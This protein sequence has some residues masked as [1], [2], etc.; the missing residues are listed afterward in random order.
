MLGLV[1]QV[2]PPI[3]HLRDLRVG[4]VRMGP[5]VVRALLLPLP[6]EPRQIR[7]RRRLDA[8]GL[9]QLRQEVLI[10][11][12]RVAPHDAAQRRVGL[13]RRRVDADRLALDQA[14]VRQP[15]QHPREDGLVRLEIDQATRA[16]DRRMVRRRLRQHQ[17]EKL[18]QRK[19][20]GRTP[21][22]RALRVQAFEIADQQQPEVAAR[23]QAGP[24]LVR[25]E[26]LRTVL[27]R[28]RRSRARRGSDSAACRTDARHCAAG[29]GSP[30]TST[31]ASRA[32]FVCP[33]PSAT[34]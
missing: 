25:V 11:L 27:R 12:A 16:R 34:V 32:A 17:P 14:R 2:R 23:R 33:S 19:R 3:L 22:D 28:T 18:A 26:S 30:P 9:R 13:Q 8:R 10:A 4:I 7:A 24:A 29:P 5:V 15:L 20:I 1:R 6:I 21:R 31:P